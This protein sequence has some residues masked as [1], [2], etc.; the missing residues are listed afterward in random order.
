[1]AEYSQIYIP[2]LVLNVLAMT[3]YFVCS[4]LILIKFNFNMDKKVILTMFCH[5]AALSIKMIAISFI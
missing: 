3:T 2:M 4:L 1:M 5:L